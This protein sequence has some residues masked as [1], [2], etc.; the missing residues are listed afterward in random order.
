MIHCST[1]DPNQILSWFWWV[2]DL[3]ALPERCPHHPLEAPP[4]YQIWDERR[5]PHGNTSIPINKKATCAKRY[6]KPSLGWHLHS[7]FHCLKLD[8]GPCSKHT[9][10]KLS[11]GGRLELTITDWHPTERDLLKQNSWKLVRRG[12]WP[13]DQHVRVGFFSKST[14]ERPTGFARGF[15]GFTAPLTKVLPCFNLYKS[16]DGT[17]HFIES[18]RFLYRQ[19]DMYIY[20]PLCNL[21]FAY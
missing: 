6:I 14:W 19:L 17:E 8:L 21:H 16:T 5:P 20:L 18:P 13:R 12:A 4:S 9:Y 1:C 2:F 10:L 15:K 7:P 11:M 3:T